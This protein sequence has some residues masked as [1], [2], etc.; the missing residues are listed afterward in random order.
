MNKE[1]LHFKVL[2]SFPNNVTAQFNRRRAESLGATW[3]LE[4]N[5]LCITRPGVVITHWFQNPCWLSLDP[6]G[7]TCDSRR[8]SQAA[9]LLAPERFLSRPSSADTAALVI[10]ALIQWRGTVQHWTFSDKAIEAILWSGSGNTEIDMW[11][12]ILENL[13]FVSTKTLAA[14]AWWLFY[15]RKNSWIYIYSTAHSIRHSTI[16]GH[17]SY[18]LI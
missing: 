8:F 5:Q 3:T 7:S 16:K 2:P 13:T 14:K 9:L 18:S 10:E 17:L 12:P 15:I 6:N 4:Q 1:G 11:N